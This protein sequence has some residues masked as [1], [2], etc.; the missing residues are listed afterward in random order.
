MESLIDRN[1][2]GDHEILRDPYAYFEAVRARGPIHTLDSG[3]VVVTGHEEVLEVLRNTAD[4][5]SA[6]APQGPAAAL[7]FAPRG[8]DITPQIEAHRTDFIGGDL[9]IGYDDAPHS[10][11]RALLNCL[12]TPSRLRANEAF[13]TD[14]ADRLVRDA[15]ASGNVEL[16]RR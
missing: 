5:S 7:P 10:R 16:I 9:L 3:I 11:S 4:F 12:F 8:S 13:I 14:Y 15:V 6:L 2:F 1:Y